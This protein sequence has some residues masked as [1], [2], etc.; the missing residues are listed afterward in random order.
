MNE[1][2]YI[3]KRLEV[4]EIDEDA[5]KGMPRNLFRAWHGW[6]FYKIFLLFRAAK[7]YYDVTYNST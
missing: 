6:G 1:G 3:S 4:E 5:A 2:I 7:V